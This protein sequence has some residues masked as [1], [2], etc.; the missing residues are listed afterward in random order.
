MLLSIVA[1]L[2]S[3]N[4]S[5]GTTYSCVCEFTAS[6][7]VFCLNE[8]D[9]KK[10]NDTAKRP[11]DLFSQVNLE[12]AWSK[13]FRSHMLSDMSDVIKP[14]ASKRQSSTSMYYVKARKMD[15]R[16]QIVASSYYAIDSKKAVTAEEFEKLQLSE[17][18]QGDKCSKA[19]TQLGTKPENSKY[20]TEYVS[21]KI[22]A[23]KREISKDGL[24]VDATGYGAS[25]Y[26]IAPET[27]VYAFARC[28]DTKTGM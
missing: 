12:K 6:M 2:M 24:C 10:V 28:Y 23:L 14:T 7:D 21:E 9:L 19:C 27:E 16:M 13:K 22:V 1:L 20:L 11:Q 25:K 3:A 4:L 15:D 8:T 26:Y 17:C 18:T 5:A